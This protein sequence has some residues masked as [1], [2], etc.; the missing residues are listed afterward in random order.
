MND[1]GL[2]IYSWKSEEESIGDENLLSGF[3]TALNHFAQGERGED[4]KKITL[5][6]TTFIFER[7]G[8]LVF[9]ILTKDP[10]FEKIIWEILQTLVSEFIQMFEQEIKDFGGNISIFS[11]FTDVVSKTFDDFLYWDY[12]RNTREFFP[13]SRYIPH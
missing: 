3:I 11:K 9:L 4:L 1:A 5:D 2:P 8:G 12:I 13:R 10:E 6:P 7:K